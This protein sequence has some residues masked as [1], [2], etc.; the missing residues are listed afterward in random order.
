MAQEPSGTAHSPLPSLST[1]FLAPLAEFSNLGS[2]DPALPFSQLIAFQTLPTSEMEE[3]QQSSSISSCPLPLPC[4]G[5]FLPPRIP[6][7][8]SGAPSPQEHWAGGPCPVLVPLCSLPEVAPAAAIVP[9]CPHAGV[10]SWGQSRDGAAPSPLPQLQFGVKATRAVTNTS[11][12]NPLL[13]HTN[14]I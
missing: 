9:R 1:V 3:N 8:F 14:L 11:V 5:S 6:Q 4:L 7:G 2:A 13:R 10:A 12:T